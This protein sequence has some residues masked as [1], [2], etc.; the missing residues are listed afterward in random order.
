[1]RNLSL[2]EQVQLTP[3]A[4][5]KKKKKELTKKA[6]KVSKT[7]ESSEKKIFCQVKCKLIKNTWIIFL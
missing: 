1:M 5:K 2:L 7:S 3:F 6:E 4:K